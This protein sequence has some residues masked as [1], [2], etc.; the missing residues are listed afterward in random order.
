MLLLPDAAERL[1]AMRP[2]LLVELCRDTAGV[3]AR[4]VSPFYS[5]PWMVR[6]VWGCLHTTAFTLLPSHYCL[7]TTAFH[8]V[9]TQRPYPLSILHGELCQPFSTL[10]AT[11]PPL[12]HSRACIT[13]HTFPH[14]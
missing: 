12:T 3:A 8:M 13:L 14:T 9:N 10:C 1:E 11:Y 6:E 5:P 7:H 4:M 2:E